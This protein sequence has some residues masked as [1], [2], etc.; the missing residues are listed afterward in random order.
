MLKLSTNTRYGT[1]ILVYLALQ[2]PDSLAR[3][4]DIANKE[5]ISSHY[6]EQILLKLRSAGLAKSLRG[7]KGGFMLAKAPESITVSDIIEATEGPVDLAP[8]VNKP[9]HNLKHCVAHDVWEQAS[10]A[11]NKIFTETTIADMANKIK[12]QTQP[13]ALM[14]NI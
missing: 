4:Q 5:N 1:R 12:V 10:Q 2:S 13:A 9:C 6:V 14:Y 3:R 7:A 8:C 11:L